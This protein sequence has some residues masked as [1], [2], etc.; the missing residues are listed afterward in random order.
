MIHHDCVR[1]SEI[2]E[3]FNIYKS[4]IM[5]YHIN[6][7]KDKEHMFI[8]NDAENAFEIMQNPS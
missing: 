6:R 1:S 8:S 2:H 3:W 5:T 4:K 7:M